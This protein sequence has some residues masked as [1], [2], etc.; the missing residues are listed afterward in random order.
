M[1]ETS[2]RLDD[3]RALAEQLGL[4][5]ASGLRLVR[6]GYGFQLWWSFFQQGPRFSGEWEA[7]AFYVRWAEGHHTAHCDE[8]VRWRRLEPIYDALL[9]LDREDALFVILRYPVDHEQDLPARVV[10][11]QRHDWPLRGAPCVCRRC[12][13]ERRG[14]SGRWRY[15][16]HLTPGVDAVGR[17]AGQCV[18]REAP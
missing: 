1:S 3:L 14:D 10:S 9:E 15:V 18:V 6:T 11:F 2:D 12:G 4:G 17:T 7:L 16:L 8:Y 5:S 13:L